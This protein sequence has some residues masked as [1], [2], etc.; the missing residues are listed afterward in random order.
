MPATAHRDWAKESETR[1]E[2]REIVEQY[3]ITDCPTRAAG[4]IATGFPLH[5]A[6]LEPGSQMRVYTRDVQGGPGPQVKI[7]IVRYR[8]GDWKSTQDDNPLARPARV[9]WS[10]SYEQRTPGF[11]ALGNPIRNTAGLPFNPP[12]PTPGTILRLTIVRNEAFYDYDHYSQF[13][14]TTNSNRFRFTEETWIEVGNA[15]C[16]DII[17]GNEYNAVNEAYVEMVFRFAIKRPVQPAQG[18]IWQTGQPLY[19]HDSHIASQGDMGWWDDSGTKRVG[20]FCDQSG[21]LLGVVDLDADGL[22]RPPSTTGEQVYVKGNGVARSP[23][24]PP[25]NIKRLP[26]SPYS[27][28]NTGPTFLLKSDYGESDFSAIGI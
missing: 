7:G 18:A 15:L 26:I 16:E 5:N 6:Q 12:P 19:P 17:P 28:Q 10:R 11:D 4:F 21:N 14:A 2:R 1:G 3:T 8:E 25:E 9:S 13:V 22:P 24:A 27:I 20:P 23:V